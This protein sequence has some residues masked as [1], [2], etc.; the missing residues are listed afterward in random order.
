M[1][2]T[3]EIRRMDDLGRVVIPKEVRKEL[4]LRKYDNF[5]IFIDDDCIIFKKYNT[6]FNGKSYGI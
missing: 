6:T 4:N 1:R 3:G 5:E 2:T